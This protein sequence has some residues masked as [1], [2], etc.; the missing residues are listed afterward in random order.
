M[1]RRSNIWQ[2]N[3]L[4]I[5]DYKFIRILEENIETFY[6]SLYSKKSKKYGVYYFQCK[7]PKDNTFCKQFITAA[8][9]LKQISNPAVCK[10]YGWDSKIGEEQ[11]HQGKKYQTE[12]Y[13]LVTEYQPSNVDT[14]ILQGKKNMK[15]INRENIKVFISQI[16][17]LLIELDE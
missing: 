14:L 7:S 13:F 6:Y 17:M 15:P 16:I 2:K 5:D 3:K 9:S 12:E 11:Y 10:I 4:N 8:L 1:Q